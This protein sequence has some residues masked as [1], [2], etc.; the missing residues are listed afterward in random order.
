[1]ETMEDSGGLRV[2]GSKG[3]VATSLPASKTVNQLKIVETGDNS[4]QVFN[5]SKQEMDPYAELELYLAK[6][7]VSPL[8]R[9]FEDLSGKI[10]IDS[11]MLTLISDIH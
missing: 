6:V 1:M 11:F 2:D 4:G 10:Q 7:K 3:T 9:K 5:G 8:W